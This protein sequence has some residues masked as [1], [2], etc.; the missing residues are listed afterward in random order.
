MAGFHGVR[1]QRCFVVSW[2]IHVVFPRHHSVYLFLPFGNAWHCIYR[3]GVVVVAATTCVGGCE[4]FWL[5]VAWLERVCV[6]FLFLSLITHVV[7]V[8]LDFSIFSLILLFFFYWDKRSPFQ[9][10]CPLS[11]SLFCRWVRSAPPSRM[12]VANEGLFDSRFPTKNVKNPVGDEPASWGGRVD[13]TFLHFFQQIPSKSFSKCCWMIRKGTKVFT[14]FQMNNE[15]T[16]LV[17]LYR[18]L[19]YPIK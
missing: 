1:I 17:G 16:W 19:Y 6:V 8:A 15:K 14:I 7:H 2:L 9:R 10:M 5:M 12:T 4:E 3:R 13:P 11:C 18:G